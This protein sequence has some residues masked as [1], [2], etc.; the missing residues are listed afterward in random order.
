MRQ[1]RIRCS[2]AEA[3]TI[4]E[5]MGLVVMQWPEHIWKDW[6]AAS[7]MNRVSLTALM[8]NEQA[9]WQTGGENVKAF[10]KISFRSN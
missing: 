1:Y 4:S 5:N 6:Q 7:I 10:E 3:V 2:L 8:G 9:A